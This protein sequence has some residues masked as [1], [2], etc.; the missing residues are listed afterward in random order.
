M[1]QIYFREEKMEA[2]VDGISRLVKKSVACFLCAWSVN[3]DTKK[4]N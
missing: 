4:K 1:S 2:I 3:C